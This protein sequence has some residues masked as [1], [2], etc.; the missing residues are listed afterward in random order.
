MKSGFQ[1]AS[2]SRLRLTANPSPVLPKLL[3]ALLLG[4]LLPGLLL[5]TGC[6]PWLDAFNRSTSTPL[7]F[8]IGQVEAADRP[9]TL[10]R[11]WRNHP[12]AENSNHRDG[13]SLLGADGSPT[14]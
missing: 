13:A 7:E 2:S 3:S 11:D 8:R 12:A 9:R 14:R 10:H 6:T 5:L 1:L 4:L